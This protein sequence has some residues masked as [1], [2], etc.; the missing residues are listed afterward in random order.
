MERSPF[1]VIFEDES[2]VINE[3]EPGNAI[4]W[5]GDRV[6][7]CKA[8][9]DIE[10]YYGFGEK[11]MRLDRRRH[12]MTMWNTDAGLHHP[13]SDPLY[14]DIPF[15]IGHRRGRSY[16]IFFDNTWKSVFNMGGAALRYAYFQAEGGEANY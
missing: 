16:G 9:P 8:M 14:V 5:R 12:R 13:N 1:R 11:L 2:G 7:C 15:Y 6:R 4:G 3:D 10:H